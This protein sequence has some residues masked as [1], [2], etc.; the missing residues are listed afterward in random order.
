M[1]HEVK[2]NSLLQFIQQNI[3]FFLKREHPNYVMTNYCNYETSAKKIELHIMKELKY[4]AEKDEKTKCYFEYND[5]IP[6]PFY[7]CDVP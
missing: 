2:R 7:L 4:E 5:E 1:V 6:D 3:R